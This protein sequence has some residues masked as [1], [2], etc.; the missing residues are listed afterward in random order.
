MTRIAL[1]TGAS[2]GL[3]KGI[4]LALGD[5][6]WTVY[7]TGRTERGEL[8]I[9][10]T[11]AEVDARGGRAVPVRCDHADDAQVEAVFEQIRTDHGRLDL[12]V[13]NCFAI[14]R[15]PIWTTPFWEQP[16]ASWD[17]MH[18][19]G[20]R[21]HYVASRFA[22]PLLFESDR[23]LIVNVSS[24]AGGGY[25][26]DVAYGVGKAGV[27]RLARDMA[28][29]LRPRGVAAVSVW[30]GVVRTEWVMENRDA[31]P[32]P[33]EVTESPEFT[34]RVIAA[35]A[36]DADVMTHSGQV[37]VVAELAE[38][39]GVDDVDGTRPRSLRRKK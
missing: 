1:V 35:L 15:E 19:V 8:S 21:S 37:L 27:D 5:A 33:F 23:P 30:P 14:P 16:I 13:N 24:F 28:H 39:Y 38:R 11:A 9:G 18:T 29:E 6:G 4:A 32:F 26:L 31:L 17:L 36:D 22:V 20:L 25:Q 10:A 7:L 12:L 2:R 34:G 3:G